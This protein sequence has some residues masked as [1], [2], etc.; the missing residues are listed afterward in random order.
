MPLLL[1]AE[2]EVDG[3]NHLRRPRTG[4][5]IGV[6]RLPP[7]S[8]RLRLLAPD[9]PPA[10]SCS[11]ASLVYPLGR[12]PCGQEGGGSA[13]ALPWVL[14]LI[15]MRARACSRVLRGCAR[16]C[17][18][19][20]VNLPRAHFSA[21]Y[22]TAA[23]LKCSYTA[24]AHYLRPMTSHRKLV[25]LIITLLVILALASFGLTDAAFSTGA[26]ASVAALTCFC[27]GN[28]AEHWSRA[29][30]GPKTEI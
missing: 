6:G 27:G 24:A 12:R 4:C 20:L 13:H 9:G 11:G 28:A 8:R 29:R 7:P 16:P 22:Y 2:G 30:K 21:A 5:P 26:Y 23:L 18:H 10:S 15:R 17:T 14:L 1:T 3:S 25:A 19:C